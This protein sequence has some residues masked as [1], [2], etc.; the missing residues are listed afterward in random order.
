MKLC[1]RGDQKA[2]IVH[3]DN[4]WA[5]VL[6]LPRRCCHTLST[7]ERHEIR[8]KPPGAPTPQAA[9]AA[10]APRAAREAAHGPDPSA[11]RGLQ[12]KPAQLGCS[13]SLAST[14][15]RAEQVLVKAPQI[16]THQLVFGNQFIAKP[17]GTAAFNEH[18]GSLFL[19]YCSIFPLGTAP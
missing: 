15:F 5:S 19:F 14:G 1:R 3:Q 18:Q 11:A 4:T 2:V 10:L 17:A 6:P 7:K 8:R 16:L 9:P 13:P 12:A